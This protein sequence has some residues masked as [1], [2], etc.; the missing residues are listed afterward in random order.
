MAATIIFCSKVQCRTSLKPY[1]LCIII[2]MLNLETILRTIL[3]LQGDGEFRTWSKL[4]QTCQRDAVVLLHLIII[5]LVAE[6]E[7]A[8][9]ASSGWFR[10]CGRNSWRESPSR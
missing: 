9:P 1:N 3:V 7:G 6:C 8:Y 2:S 5:I 4:L 10:G